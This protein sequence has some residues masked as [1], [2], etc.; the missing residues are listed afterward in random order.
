MIKI[1]QYVI[2]L[3]LS[4]HLACLHTLA[5]PIPTGVYS[6]RSTILNEI[7]RLQKQHKVHFVYD[8]ALRLD[9]TYTGPDLCLMPLN[10]ALETL[11]HQSGIEYRQINNNI[12]LKLSATP[13]QHPTAEHKATFTIRGLI[14]DIQGEPIV[15]ATIFD[16]TT[17][18][19]TLSDSR[20]RYLL[21]LTEGRHRLRVSSIGCE[22][23][24]L[25]INK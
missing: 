12:L 18:D 2:P 16:L 13:V 14:T 1:S 6:N 25:D 22:A 15:N 24:T 17:K 11:F 23:D 4:L 7:R 20:G 5:D 8:S 21:H 9:K 3:F 10:K 19:G